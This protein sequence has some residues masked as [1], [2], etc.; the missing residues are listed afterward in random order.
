MA[1]R[2]SSS[3]SGGLGFVIL[4]KP[5]VTGKRKRSWHGAKPLTLFFFNHPWPFHCR[6]IDTSPFTPSLQGQ[7]TGLIKGLLDW[8]WKKRNLAWHNITWHDSKEREAAAFIRPDRSVTAESQHAHP[9]L[10]LSPEIPP[11]PRGDFGNS[12][13]IKTNN[14][15]EAS[16]HSATLTR[17]PWLAVAGFLVADVFFTCQCN[18]SF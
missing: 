3:L 15:P 17:L 10:S 9:H 4:P 2:K 5:P 13:H 11:F 8:T 14:K 12:S 1:S 16:Q 7:F 6:R 18:Q